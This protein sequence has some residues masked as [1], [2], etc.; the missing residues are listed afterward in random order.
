VI[1][2]VIASYRYGHLAAHCIESILSQT[3]RPERIFFVDDAAGDCL[4]LPAIYPEVSYIFRPNNLGIVANFQDMLQRVDSEYTLFLG[5][6]NWLRS[7]AIDKLSC[8]TTD[9]ITYDIIVTGELKY[10]IMQR[11]ADETTLHLGDV[12]W[13]RYLKHHGSMAY[14]TSF[15]RQ[16]G[17]KK[18]RDEVSQPE[19]DW[20]LWT[21]M[22]KKG[23]TVQHIPEALLYY[24]RHRE[25]HLKYD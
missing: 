16:V 11:H 5:A 3:K 4:H 18:F 10:E 6:D 19:E 25:N 24:R 22:L 7:D 8:A 17:Y 20:Y 9:I 14:R 21:E 13:E 23:A 1:T 2:V 12:Y 15:G